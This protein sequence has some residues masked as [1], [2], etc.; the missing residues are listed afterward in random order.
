M[1]YLQTNLSEIVNSNNC[2][3][4]T[5]RKNPPASSSPTKS[6]T[7]TAKARDYLACLLEPTGIQFNGPNPWDIQVYDE[8]VYPRLITGASMAMGEAYMDGWWSCPRIDEMMFRI[9]RHGVP[10]RMRRWQ[11]WLAILRSTIFNLQ[12]PHRAGQIGERHYDLGNRLFSAMLDSRLI[13][14]CAYWRHSRNLEEAQR[15]KLK[16]LCDKLDL[17]L[18]DE[19]LDIGCGWGGLLRFAAERYGVSA[20]GLTVSSEQVAKARANVPETLPVQILM[21]D[22]RSHKSNYDRIVSVGMFEHVG[23]KNHRTFFATCRQ[24]LKK[25]DNLLVLQTIV[26]NDSSAKVDPWIAK[27]IFP[28]SKLP[29]AKQIA[30]ASEGLFII[31]DWQNFGPDYDRTLMAWHEKFVTAWPELRNDY[32]ERFRRMWEYYLLSC[33]GS[34]RARNIQLCQIVFSPQGRAGVR[35]DASR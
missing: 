9:L 19:L 23:V 24:R 14:S 7:S 29:S 12:N 33:A 20:T 27:Y 8:R 11:D 13:Y 5:R 18:G 1:N 15:A 16:L 30:C 35:Y 4:K 34:F 2:A 10:V 31:E 25:A 3:T 26:A 6:N 17:R 32:S 21:E 22:Y 28:N